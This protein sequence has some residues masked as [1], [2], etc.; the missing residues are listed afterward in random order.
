[1]WEYNVV[2]FEGD[3]A[4]LLDWLN[5]L[6]EQGWELCDSIQIRGAVTGSTGL[7]LYT[8][9]RKKTGIVRL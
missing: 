9:K 5:G 4:D 8:F 2:Y 7:R 6:G 3:E 1:M